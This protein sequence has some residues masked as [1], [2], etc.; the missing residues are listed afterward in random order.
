[1]ILRNGN[2]YI[3]IRSYLIPGINV[4]SRDKPT[5]K[6]TDIRMYRSRYSGPRNSHWHSLEKFIETQNLNA[7]RINREG[8]EIACYRLDVGNVTV[9]DS[10]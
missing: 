2:I 9:S 10:A 7:K 8:D 3:Y 4:L 1:M 6:S 5:G